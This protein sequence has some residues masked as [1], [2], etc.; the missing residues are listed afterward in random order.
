M[1]EL[2]WLLAVGAGSLVGFSLG[3]VGGG[4]SILAVPLLVYVV[5]VADP[6]IA[7][8]TSAVAVAANAAVNLALH[9]RKGTVKWR[10]A[11]LFAAMG[12]VGAWLGAL[13]GQRMDGQRLLSLFAVLMIVVGALMLR[14]RQGEGDPTV[15]LGRENFPRL[16]ASGLGTGLVSGFFG[17]GGGFLIVP[18][19]VWSTGMPIAMAMAS[20]LV[21]VTAFGVTTASSYAL[22]GRVDWPVAGLF[23]AGG[24]LGGLLGGALATRLARRRGA[25]NAL[26][27]GLIFAV[28]AYMLYRSLNA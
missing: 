17:I 18:G 1:S 14:K 10:C 28:A 6:H 22:S 16:T 13:I 8:G 15:R 11:S 9:A 19:L 26:F 7:I 25:L 12:V 23:I 24:V 5:G 2:S 21:A 3:L 4:G 27:A 20:S